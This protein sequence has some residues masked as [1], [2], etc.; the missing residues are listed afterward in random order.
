MRELGKRKSKKKAKAARENGKLGGRPRKSAKLGP[1]NTKAFVLDGSDL[2]TIQGRVKRHTLLRLDSF[3][4]G[5]AG[6]RLTYKELI[7]E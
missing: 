5:I 4:D 2:G 7:A 6:R 1:G 3:V